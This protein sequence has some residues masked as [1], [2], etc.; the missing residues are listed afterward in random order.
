VNAVAAMQMPIGCQA[1]GASD[2][3]DVA[4]CPGYKCQ[5]LSTMLLLTRGAQVNV[6]RHR[7]CS[8]TTPS[9]SWADLVK[10]TKRASVQSQQRRLPRPSDACVGKHIAVTGD[11]CRELAALHLMTRKKLNHG[12]PN[13]LWGHQ[14]GG[15]IQAVERSISSGGD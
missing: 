5:S 7:N 8:C 15:V 6:E 3:P 4:G 1:G 11:L 9:G 2:R 10:L 13:C 12:A 14:N